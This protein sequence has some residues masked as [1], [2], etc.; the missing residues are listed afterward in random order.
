MS[1]SLSLEALLQGL[2][3]GKE[4]AATE[5][6]RVY[7]PEVRLAVHLRLA[8]RRLRRLL[9]SQDVCQDVLAS[10][11]RRIT[12]GEYRIETREDLLKLLRTMARNKL[13]KQVERQRAARRDN[14]R[15]A[16]VPPEDQALA[17]AGSTPSKQVEAKDLAQE[18]HRRLSEEE[19]RLAEL[20]SQGYGWPDIAAEVGGNADALRMKL[21]RAVKRVTSQVGKG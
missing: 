14:R 6:V 17:A 1:E 19:W 10:F 8:D 15:V 3:A 2:R 7:G 5:L 20:K 13:A 18:L 9:D 16:E 11:F 4:E 21:M 12:L